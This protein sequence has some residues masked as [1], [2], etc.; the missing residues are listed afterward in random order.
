MRSLFIS[1][2]VIILGGCAAQPD[3]IEV[4]V[5]VDVPVAISCVSE[6]P[7]EPLYETS[8]LISTDDIG[9]VAEAF[10][11]EIEQR[12]IESAE[13]RA[14]LAGCLMPLGAQAQMLPLANPITKQ[15]M[16]E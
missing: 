12:K 15:L 9:A 2:L 14:L 16:Y 11:V 7:Q 13:L 10:M 5:Y 8:L 6:I 1:W 4:P 3:I